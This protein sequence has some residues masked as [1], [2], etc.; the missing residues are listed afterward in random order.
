LLA[1]AR[2]DGV[3]GL[4][5]T[6]SPEKQQPNVRK[7]PTLPKAIHAQRRRVDAVIA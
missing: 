5:A 4:G 1:T 2:G 3:D 6:A 7:A